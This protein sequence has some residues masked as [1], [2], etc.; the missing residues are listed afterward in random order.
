MYLEENC[1]VLRKV[2]NQSRATYA[3][4]LFDL[5]WALATRNYPSLVRIMSLF[6]SVRVLV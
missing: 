2:E 1:Y 6:A 5:I 3:Q 4:A